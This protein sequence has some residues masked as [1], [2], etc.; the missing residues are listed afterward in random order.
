MKTWDTNFL[1]RHLLEDDAPQLAVVRKQL[2]ASER[3]GEP[4]FLPQIVL[5]ETAWVLRSLLPKEDVLATL[6]EVLDDQRFQCE[7]AAEVAH[8]L[9]AAAKRG[10]ISDHLIGSAA[11]RAEATP[12]QTFDRALLRAKPFEVHGLKS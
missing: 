9:K 4:I 10:D 1:L 7:S 11:V 8:A 5:V 6:K 2:N 12:V 3:R